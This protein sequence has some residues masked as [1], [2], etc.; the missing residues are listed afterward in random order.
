M[1]ETLSVFVLAFI[2]IAVL[3][4]V[5]PF[6]SPIVEKAYMPYCNWAEN[7]VEKWREK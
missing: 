5:I 1:L 2:I 4:A 6:I 7:K 3:L